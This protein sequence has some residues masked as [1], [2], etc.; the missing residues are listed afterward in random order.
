[1]YASRGI[2]A[3]FVEDA[4]GC[5]PKPLGANPGLSLEVPK[6]AALCAALAVVEGRTYSVGVGGWFDEDALVL[7]EYG[8]ISAANDPSIDPTVYSLEGI[9][10]LRL[11]LARG[12]QPSAEDVEEMG[13]YLA[14]WGA[15]F[16]MPNGICKY[17]DPGASGYPDDV[18]PLSAGHIY[19]VEVSMKCGLD[20]AQGPYGGDYWLIVDPPTGPPYPGMYVGDIDYGRLEL[21][22]E[23]AA[24]YR[25]EVG[26]E[27]A[28][29]RIDDWQ[30]SA[31]PC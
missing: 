8:T 2:F 25:S 30:A 18:C 17:A 5:E 31:A 22:N 19:S 9:D 21:L 26:A 1:M 28:M 13:T 11:L 12:P 24:I 4:E 14:L 20:V 27:L 29:R 16:D 6:V 23:D 10:P 15:P 3:D 7:E